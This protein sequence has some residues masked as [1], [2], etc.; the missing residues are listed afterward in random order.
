MEGRE[1]M[2]RTIQVNGGNGFEE[3]ARVQAKTIIGI[4]VKVAGFYIGARL[5]I[6]ACR[7]QSTK[8]GKR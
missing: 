5:I 7:L 8:D 4:W 2:I 6:W 1:E 3:V